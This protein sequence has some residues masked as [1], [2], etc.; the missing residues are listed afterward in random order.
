MFSNLLKYY[1]SLYYHCPADEEIT[2]KVL[3]QVRLKKQQPSIANFGFGKG[4]ECVLLAQTYDASVVAVEQNDSYLNAFRERIDREGLSGRIKTIKAPLDK[5]PFEDGSF[6]LIL[7]EGGIAYSGFGF[8]IN[9]W[10]PYLKEGGYLAL[11]ELCLVKEAE[12]PYELADY[13]CDNYPFREIGTIG[14]KLS[15]IKDAQYRLCGQ[16]KLPD[17]CWLD[18]YRDKSNCYEEMPEKWKNSGEGRRVAEY[19]GNARYIYSMYSDY[20]CYTYFIL[21]KPPVKT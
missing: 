9:S 20:F 3:K 6:D 2:K 10:K 7:S 13:L 16:Y 14:C 11:S 5:L 21:R 8:R 12:L 17:S 19:I 18:F 15:Q 4:N 1:D